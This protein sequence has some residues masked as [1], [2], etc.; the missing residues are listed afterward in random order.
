VN[1]TC[2]AGLTLAV[3]SDHL[4]HRTGIVRLLGGGFQPPPNPWDTLALATGPADAY[5]ALGR[6]PL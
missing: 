6:K 3:F 2:S 4:E 5:K 1:V